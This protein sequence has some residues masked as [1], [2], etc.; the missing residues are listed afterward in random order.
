MTTKSSVEKGIAAS[1]NL[2]TP[3]TKQS[4]KT[5][6]T[7]PKRFSFLSLGIPWGWGVDSASFGE[8]SAQNLSY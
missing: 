7:S 8:V 4:K 3:T 1:K 5:L 6:K 2:K